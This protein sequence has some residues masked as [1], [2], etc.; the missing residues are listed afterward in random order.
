M[1]AAGL[2]SR[3]QSPDWRDWLAAFP[4]QPAQD[5]AAL[6]RYE[7]DLASHLADAPDPA[8][9]D[10]REAR[11]IADDL[12]FYCLELQAQQ[13]ADAGVGLINFGVALSGFVGAVFFPPAAIPLAA[14]SLMAATVGTAQAYEQK[15]RRTIVEAVLTQLRALA[16][17]LR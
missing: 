1:T 3:V 9:L 16:W 6:T 8:L 13:Q 12:F 14:I 17:R 15:R 2:P 4:S 7:R 10:R 11:D 5:R